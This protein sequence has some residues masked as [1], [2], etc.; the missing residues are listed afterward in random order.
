MRM[1]ANIHPSYI[2]TGPGLLSLNFGMHGSL[3]ESVPAKVRSLRL[4]GG[5]C[6]QESNRASRFNKC[7]VYFMLHFILFV[8][9]L[10][11]FF[12]LM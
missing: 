12:F 10:L 7:R 2:H 4:A 11:G 9:F 5:C 8:H 6:L 3:N 1:H